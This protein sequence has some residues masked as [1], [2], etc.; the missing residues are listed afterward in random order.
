MLDVDIDEGRQCSD[1][2]PSAASEPRAM[3]RSDPG[4]PMA[5]SA[6]LCSRCNMDR[7]NGKN[8]ERNGQAF[9]PVDMSLTMSPCLVL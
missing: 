7:I 6:G 8:T 3:E 4:L 2:R 5:E 9:E 1:G